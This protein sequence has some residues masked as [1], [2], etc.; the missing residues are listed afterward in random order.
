MSGSLHLGK[1]AGIRID[2]NWSWLIIVVLLTVS[3]ATG[4]FPVIY[5]GWSPS[6][7]WIA[8]L[9]AALLLFVSVLVHELAH[10]L[11]A[12]ARGVPVKSITLFIFG[13][14]SNIEREPTSAGTDFL[15]AIVGPLTSLVIGVIAFFLGAALPP[16]NVFAAAI[17]SYLGVTN[18]LLGAFNLIPGFPL[19]GGRVLRS[20]LWGLS[21][22]IQTATRWASW[23]GEAVAMLFIIAGVF[24]LFFVRGGFLNGLWLAFIGWFLW[25]A[26]RTAN[27]QVMLRGL[28]GG[29]TVADVMSRTP[30]MVSG[31]LTL[32]Q[33]MN[34]Y[35]LAQGVRAALVV[36]DGHLRGLITLADLRLVPQE[37]WE[38]EQVAQAMVPAAQLHVVS[39]RQS[40]NDV[41][42]LM[43]QQDIN[44]LPVVE[45]G[46]VV[47]VVTRDRVM[48]YIEVLR[49]LKAHGGQGPAREIPTPPPQAPAS[50]PTPTQ[51]GAV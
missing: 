47:G 19:D 46:Q 42:P 6:A 18:L 23:I 1:I 24:A 27:T 28:L 5:S 50:P 26:A 10:S 48:Q 17:L 34:A 3:L 4:W 30:V 13:G 44:Q 14:V 37:R 29:V 31:D 51:A 45:N 22:S 49:E 35:M 12:R 32:R 33:F 20:I 16:V 40:L 25:Q 2:L 8:G 21:G 15:I 43:A 36:D 41:L 39:P 7:Y 38:Q 9:L 11:M